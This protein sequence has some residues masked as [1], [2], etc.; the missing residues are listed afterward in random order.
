MHDFFLSYLQK[1]P[2]YH[3]CKKLRTDTQI[4]TDI[5][6]ADDNKGITPSEL[7]FCNVYAQL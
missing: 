1:I 5:R 7:L 3:A 6:W 2:V 4:H